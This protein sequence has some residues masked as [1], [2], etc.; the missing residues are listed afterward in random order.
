MLQVF[1]FLL[2]VFLPPPTITFRFHFYTLLC[3]F[4]F[5]HEIPNISYNS[6]FL[7]YLLFLTILAFRQSRNITLP[8]VV[9][10]FCKYEQVVSLLFVLFLYILFFIVACWWLYPWSN[11]CNHSPTH[12]VDVLCLLVIEHRNQNNLWVLSSSCNMVNKSKWTSYKFAVHSQFFFYFMFFFG[13]ENFTSYFLFVYST[14]VA[15][16]SYLILPLLFLF[17]TLTTNQKKIV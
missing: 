1:I 2:T 15:E 5:T 10:I 13:V 6:F 9:Y 16:H 12:Y 17:M 8:L 4:I 11:H 14:R 7:P 3:Y